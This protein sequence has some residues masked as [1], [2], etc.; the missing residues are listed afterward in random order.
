[1]DK[2]S[3]KFKNNLV[4]AFGNMHPQYLCISMY[5][6][7]CILQKAF[8]DLFLNLLLFLSLDIDFVMAKLFSVI[9]IFSLYHFFSLTNLVTILRNFLRLSSEI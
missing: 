6:W 1:M 8:T 3:N 4:K 9:I 2:N 5:Y 7:R